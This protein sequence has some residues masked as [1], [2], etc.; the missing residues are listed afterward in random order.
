MLAAAGPQALYPV[1]YMD[2][3]GGEA[4]AGSARIVEMPCVM[5]LAQGLGLMSFACG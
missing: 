5:V 3:T 4:A 1:L 2:A